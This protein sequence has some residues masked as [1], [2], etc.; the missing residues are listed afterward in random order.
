MI[1]RSSKLALFLIMAVAVMGF[2]IGSANAFNDKDFFQKAT[3]GNMME[4]QL[5]KM[6]LNQSQ[7]NEVKQ[8]AQRILDDHNKVK[9]QLQ[10]IASKDNLAEPRDMDRSQHRAVKSL[11]G[12]KGHDFDKAFTKHM[13]N[14]HKDDIKLFDKA[15]KDAKNADLKHFA[16][17][18]LPV[19]NDHLKMAKDL[20]TKVKQRG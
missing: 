5:A 4:I 15:S 6:A 10:T 18:Q 11:S 8:F 1:T 13:V 3:T 20:E 19:L 14:D 7:N 12:K 16:A 2:G 17:Q 9:Q